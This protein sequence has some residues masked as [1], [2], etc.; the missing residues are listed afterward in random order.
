MIEEK[1]QLLKELLAQEPANKFEIKKL[2]F[3]LSSSE[4]S[5]IIDQLSPKEQKKFIEV[6]FSTEYRFYVQALKQGQEEYK[7]YCQSQDYI[8]DLVKQHVPINKKLAQ[9]LRKEVEKERADLVHSEEYASLLYSALCQHANYQHS[10]FT[11]LDYL[12]QLDLNLEYL[13]LYL[14]FLT[15]HADQFMER[16]VDA[17]KESIKNS[18]YCARKPLLLEQMLASLENN[19]KDSFLVLPVI[20]MLP[21]SGIHSSALIVHKEDNKIMVTILDK[22]MHYL[23]K[24][25]NTY[26]GIGVK[27]I[28]DLGISGFFKGLFTGD[29]DKNLKVAL[30]YV[31]E[32]TDTS[33]IRTQLTYILALGTTF[34]GRNLQLSLFSE[35]KESLLIQNKLLELAESSYWG[36]QIYDGQFF[37]KNC[38]I[39]SVSAAMQ[40]VLGD[41]QTTNKYMVNGKETE[42]RK[43]PGH[44]AK[45]VLVTLAE[46]MKI[47]I[48]KLGYSSKAVEVIDT[49]T[50]EYCEQKN[51]SRK[52]REKINDLKELGSKYNRQKIE[53]F[54]KVTP[55]KVEVGLSPV[56]QTSFY[57]TAQ[58][59]WGGLGKNSAQ[60]ILQLCSVEEIETVKSAIQT[61]L[62]IH[63]EKTAERRTLSEVA[64]VKGDSNKAKEEPEK[65]VKKDN[66][67]R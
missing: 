28:S 20:Q 16:E 8:N 7:K 60:M 58:H 31:L 1:L 15:V 61:T 35:K 42:L 33:E 66:L 3:T 13:T 48:Q 17:L 56:A 53:L 39:K 4:K 2:I 10:N 65:Q 24:I 38:Y 23:D 27:E 5:E 32:F 18:I 59:K 49:L 67:E 57:F 19:N 62:A 40:H 26:P 55:T 50:A 46:I 63:Q 52:A 45:E 47:R 64:N 34:V 36:T 54:E 51:R 12:T 6:T 29:I 43:I 22:G 9:E 25:S 41:K 44:S 37:G 30:P 14:D 11:I 21:Q